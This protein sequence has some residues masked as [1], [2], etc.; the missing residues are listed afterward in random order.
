MQSALKTAQERLSLSERGEEMRELR[1][2]LLEAEEQMVAML[3]A[4]AH[5][6]D[7]ATGPAASAP[8]PGRDLRQGVS[9]ERE[10][11]ISGWGR[12]E[13]KGGGEGG[14]VEWTDWAEGDGVQ[15]WETEEN[16]VEN[17]DKPGGGERRP[18]EWW[19]T[20]KRFHID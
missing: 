2:R 8:A 7:E 14:G 5:R 13:G 20:L 12:G 6:D 16:N 18:G 9:L 19:R 11:F 4:S 1:R 15:G 10:K 3:E 17:F